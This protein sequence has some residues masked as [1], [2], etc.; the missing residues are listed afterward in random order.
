MRL[1][2]NYKTNV[3]L[4]DSFNR[5]AHRTFGIDFEAWYSQGF[6]D[7]RYDAYSFVDGS[8]VVSNVSVSKL[9][10]VW[11]GKRLRALHIGT[12]MTDE[13]YRGRGL[14]R[15]L[16]E[17]VLDKYDGQFDVIYLFANETVLDFYPKFGFKPL[18]ESSF[19][20]KISRKDI[21]KD[22]SILHKLDMN[23]DRV[24]R[25]FAGIAAG[26]SPIS[27]ICGIIGGET[28]AAWYGI[29]M[30]RDCIY[31]VDGY[32]GLLV[33]CEQND[34]VLDVYDVLAGRLEGIDF[35]RLFELIAGPEVRKVRLHFTPDLLNLETTCVPLEEGDRLFV[36]TATI[37]TNEPFKY[38]LTAQA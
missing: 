13:A 18:M 28:I 15:R 25:R 21:S 12:V 9:D 17:H 38:P 31:E 37:M 7:D 10:W 27:R 19:E 29:Y 32:D 14:C 35:S 36:K 23:D 26:R 30:F 1:I 5:L 20:Y 34:D 11:G 4:R 22:S 8:E 3:E 33:I 2:S 16:L 24:L 6:W